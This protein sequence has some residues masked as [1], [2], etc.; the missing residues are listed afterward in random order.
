MLIGEH[1]CWLLNGASVAKSV[2]DWL[3]MSVVRLDL[4]GIEFHLPGSPPIPVD[5]VAHGQNKKSPGYF[6]GKPWDFIGKPWGSWKRSRYFIGKPW[7]F[8][9]DHGG[10]CK[11]KEG[12]GW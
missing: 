6:T 12:N 7:D 3:I 1:S 11:A 5:G 2:V 9:P 4:L 10:L 8:T